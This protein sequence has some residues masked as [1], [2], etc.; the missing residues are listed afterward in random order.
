MKK[1]ISILLGLSLVMVL[2]TSVFAAGVTFSMTADK[3]SFHVGEE[4]TINLAASIDAS[5]VATSYGLKLEFN[6][7][8]FELVSGECTAAGA[9]VANYNGK[10]WAAMFASATDY[11]GALGTAVMKVK[12]GAPAGEYTIEAIPSV[13]NGNA[14]VEAASVK[15]NVTITDHDGEWTNNGNNH[16]STC[17]ICGNTVTEDH[18][19]NAGEVTTA[20]TCGA[21]G[22]MTY[23]CSVCNAT[24]T[25]AILATGAHTY[26]AY[27]STGDAEHAA[28]CSGCGAT[29]TEAHA[30][31]FDCDTT[32]DACGFERDA[33]HTHKPMYDENNHWEGCECGDII[34]QEAHTFGEWVVIQEL[35][36]GVDGIRERTC[37]VC[38]YV[39]REV[40]PAPSTPPTGDNTNTTLLFGLTL[41]GLLG[42][43]AVL[44]MPK[45]K[46]EE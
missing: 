43:A 34:N 29:T 7:D 6:A 46:I 45:K 11:K 27:T 18:K 31:E 37:S 30:W 14:T 40:T 12:A 17:S 16:S 3:T 8:V 41:V 19:W 32:C 1:I 24:K 42:M 13:K 2:A 21:D 36:A 28:T 22:V 44:V 10:G 38:G 26:G 25:E 9:M 23:T 15:I 20:A 4:G 35:A 33:E 39:D 5:E